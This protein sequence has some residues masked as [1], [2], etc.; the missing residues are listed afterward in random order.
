MHQ[1]IFLEGEWNIRAHGVNV[2]IQ[3]VETVID[4]QTTTTHSLHRNHNNY[5]RTEDHKQFI[6]F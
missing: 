3:P 4:E 5:F 2:S 6:Y 1:D